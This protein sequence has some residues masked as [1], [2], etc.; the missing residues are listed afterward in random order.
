MP[1]CGTCGVEL[2]TENWSQNNIRK[3]YYICKTCKKEYDH[4]YAQKHKETIIEKVK[5]WQQ[6]N[7]D[8]K[9]E[10]QRRYF[11]K[12]RNRIRKYIRE[13]RAKFR[14]LVLMH[15][16]EGTMQCKYCGFSDE[17]ALSVDHINGGGTQH[18][19]TMKSGGNFCEVLVR[20]GYPKG[21]QIL[22]MNCQFIKRS[23]NER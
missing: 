20:E 12:N 13:R 19:K 11:Y 21:Y 7:P 10:M 9:H 16:S 23:E 2:K 22:C 18:R 15:Y 5:R 4:N 8:R 6:A 14:K 1:K 17:R 3:H